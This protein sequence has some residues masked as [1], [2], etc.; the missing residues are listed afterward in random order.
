MGRCFY[1]WKEL[2]LFTLTTI[3]FIITFIQFAI[4]PLD[5]TDQSI[6]SSNKES[7][8]TT[9]A[10]EEF[11]SLNFGPAAKV[12]LKPFDF[13]RSF[14]SIAAPLRVALFATIIFALVNLLY[15][16]FFFPSWRL[17][18]YLLDL[19]CPGMCLFGILFLAKKYEEQRK[20]AIA[21]TITG[22]IYFVLR[23]LFFLWPF[24][25]KNK[26]HFYKKSVH[27][28]TAI[29]LSRIIKDRST[30]EIDER[31][32]RLKKTIANYDLCL[33]F[34]ADRFTLVRKIVDLILSVVLFVTV[35]TL[36][37][38]GW[39][40]LISKSYD[41]VQLKDIAYICNII[42][43]ALLTGF[44]L[45][46]LFNIAWFFPLTYRIFK[47]LRRLA[48]KSVVLVSGLVLL[49]VLN[50]VLQSTSTTKITCDYYQFYDFRSN[51]ESF[52]QYFMKRP[53]QGCINCSKISANT[54]P[55]CTSIC[56]YDPER[57]PLQYKVLSDSNQVTENDLSS[58]YLVPVVLLEIYFLA[59]FLQMERQ[60]FQNNL[61]I[62]TSLP[63]PTK[64]IECKFVSLVNI[65]NSSGVYLFPSYRFNQALYYFNFTQIKNFVSFFASLFPVFP[66]PSV[67]E[68]AAKII[69]W[70]FFIASITIS[71]SQLFTTPYTSILHNVINGFSYFVGGIAALFAAL[72]VGGLVKLPSAVGNVLFV[73]IFVTPIGTALISP[74]FL[75]ADVALRPCSFNLPRLIKWDKK[76]LQIQ[77]RR[78]N[79]GK[80]NDSSDESISMAF[81][82]ELE[83]E[84]RVH[85]L[86]VGSFSLL[87]LA[88]IQIQKGIKK[89]VSGFSQKAA[90]VWKC[91]DVIENEIDDAAKE[92]LEMADDLL[93]CQSNNAMSMILNISVIFCSLCLGW[94]LGSGV[95][96]WKK[97]SNNNDEYYLRCNMFENG[98]YPAYGTY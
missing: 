57:A 39:E 90:D 72:Q 47:R 91:V 3:S 60:I 5:T 83:N 79:K 88:P 25:K 18:L 11:I 61:D 26:R 43:Y 33:P 30:P 95:A 56:Y 82:D 50:M 96:T 8:S 78:R 35:L 85:D 16:L 67:Q 28:I 22:V 53:N 68:Y 52:V 34:D 31:Q 20:V 48:F 40:K 46:L 86:Q 1:A 62:V 17:Y 49:P 94:A 37:C 4:I 36:Y 58:I 13:I 80:R 6:Q 15:I 93:D 21:L 73:L 97:I 14:N 98:T 38:V 32:K 74:L 59:I 27:Q 44:S 23:F 12:F 42:S 54:V 45:R 19:F 29:F 69:P 81:F 70:L 71:F 76:L 41:G 63:G 10:I 24:L 65:L 7:S 51:T 64:N 66:V 55:P 75:R 9:E 84:D 89:K 2:Q 77:K 92:M 87:K